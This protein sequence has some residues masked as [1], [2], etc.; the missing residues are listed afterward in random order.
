MTLP[1]IGSNLIKFGF[2]QSV[3]LSFD[4]GHAMGFRRNRKITILWATLLLSCCLL[5]AHGKTV[6]EELTSHRQQHVSNRGD[7]TSLFV[8]NNGDDEMFQPLL[9]GFEENAIPGGNF[10]PSDKSFPKKQQQPSSSL[11]SSGND[12]I[13]IVPNVEHIPP[14]DG[15]DS[16][17]L[18]TY[19]LSGDPVRIRLWPS[20]TGRSFVQRQ[21]Q[22]K[23]QQQG[24]QSMIVEYFDAGCYYQ[25]R[26]LDR[27]QGAETG[28]VLSTC[29]GLI[30]GT[31][32]DQDR[33][34]S[35]EFDE[36]SGEQYVRWLNDPLPSSSGSES[37]KVLSRSKRNHFSPNGLVGPYN[38][39]RHSKFVQLVLVVDNSLYRKLNSD[40]WE[41]HRYC[42]DVVNHINMLFNQLNIFIALTGVV[43]WDRYDYIQV[44]RRADDTL[45]N[46]LQYRRKE[47]LRQ[48]PNDHAQLLTAVEFQDRVIGKAKLGG[49]CTSNSSGAVI[50]VHTDKIAIQAGTLAH[51]MGHSFNMEHDEDGVCSCPDGKCIMTAMAT[52]M[53]L[54]HWSSCSTEQLSLAFNRGL[55]HCLKDRPLNVYSSS[56]GN[57]FVEEGEDCDCG[58][59]DVCDNICCDPKICR[60]KEGAICATG[61]CCDLSTCQLRDAGHVCRPH[62]GECDLPEFCTGRSEHCPRD[63]WKRNTEVCAG[64]KSHC[65]DGECKTRD[66]QCR[67]LW[68]PSGRASDEMCYLRNINGTKYANCGFDRDTH[69]FRRC[70]EQDVTCG[71]LFCHQL[72]E[73]NLE[74][75]L[76]V[77]TEENIGSV[78][79]GRDVVHCHAAFIDLGEGKQPSLVPDGAPCGENKMCYQQQCWDIDSLNDRGVGT[80]CHQDC[81][82]RGICNSEGNCHCDLG[83]A[84]P[85]C[86]YAGSGGS[87]DSGPASRGTHLALLITLVIVGVVVTTL[88]FA[89]IFIRFCRLDRC[90]KPLIFTKYHSPS[91]G[92]HKLVPTMSVNSAVIREISAPKL[93][94]STRDIDGPQFTPIARLKSTT[95]TITANRSTP[96]IPNYCEPDFPS[97][98]YHQ[99]PQHP[100]HRKLDSIVTVLPTKPSSSPSVGYVTHM[101]ALPPPSPPR[102]L[103]QINPIKTRTG[104]G[105]GRYS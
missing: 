31:V 1:I 21:G 16:L 89:Y 63:V 102:R 13:P 36:S 70:S 73:N 62:H 38:A 72:N 103:P 75:G 77:F 41:V 54:K 100:T 74:F 83:Y 29:E 20:L 6:E 64:G 52:G 86:E 78:L 10:P 26:I 93:C 9:R 14:I 12:R 85:F 99:K 101:T 104:Y 84:P 42:T 68:G 11:P 95:T 65:V 4:S 22:Q 3:Q 44:T 49:M 39:N 105:S 19:N 40:V 90:K 32:Y 82:G 47:L 25:G 60:F 2:C 5:E 17:M 34:Y 46:F 80:T 67:L 76:K 56:C 92:R 7:Q 43:V 35:I 97:P 45:N 59:D 66:D 37:E 58:L 28:A 87:L 27:K 18:L 88:F 53:S 71:L 69:S 94:S 30:R 33:T 57:G 24:N 55:S 23:E 98:I 81:N 48:H 96:T 51:E 8:T 15:V 79:K 91:R 50:V 61:E